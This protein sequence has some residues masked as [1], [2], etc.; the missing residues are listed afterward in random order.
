MNILH[1]IADAGFR[2]IA[3]D[4]RGYSPE[5]R[6]SNVE[7][8]AVEYLI[9]DVLGFADKLG[10]VRSHLVAHDWGGLLAWKIAA[11]RPDRLRSLTVLSTP[12]TDA[13]LDALETDDDQ[14]QRSKYITLFRAP[15]RAAESLFQASDY[16]RLRNVYQGKVPEQQVQE[17]VRRLA[18]PGALTAALNWYRALDL[19]ARTGVVTVPTLFVWGSHD[20]ALGEVAAMKTTQYVTG[21]YHFERLDGKSHWL[22]EEVPELISSLLLEHLKGRP[23]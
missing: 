20:L 15:G 19:K 1:P 16:A 5:A 23:L 7:Q 6:P 9:S 21:P 17:N 2:C 18:V 14:K 11:Q 13:F 10:A 3:V 22:L 8:Y 4:Q 12:H